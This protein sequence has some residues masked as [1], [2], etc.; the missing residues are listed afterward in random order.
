M[1]RRYPEVKNEC[2]ESL[3]WHFSV[4][5]KFLRDEI[6]I[7]FGESKAKHWKLFKSKVGHSKHFRK[8]FLSH[9]KVKSECCE[10]FEVTFFTF[11]QFHERRNWT[12][13]LQKW[14]KGVKAILNQNLVIESFLVICFEATL[15]SK[16]NITSVW[17]WH[18][19]FYSKCL[20]DE[21]ETVFWESEA[22]H[23]KLFQ[24]KDSDREH[25]RKWFWSYLEVKNEYSKT[26]E[27]TFFIFLQF[28]E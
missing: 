26:F 5:C 20:N 4:F 14:G 18:F 7:V 13:F 6:E 3:K 28:F 27:M 21:I 2:C 9:L 16:T 24:S 10:P 19:S 11:L 22:K 23:W 25:F 17:K 12:H 1:F 15:R 8:W